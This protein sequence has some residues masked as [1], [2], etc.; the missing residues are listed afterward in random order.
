MR[1]EVSRVAAA[2]SSEAPG[3]PLCCVRPAVGENGV[4]PTS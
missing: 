3:D 4:G 2:S 1:L